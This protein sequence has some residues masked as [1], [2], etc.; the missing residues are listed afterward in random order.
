MIWIFVFVYV[1]MFV[2]MIQLLMAYQ[3]RAYN[4]RM[5]QEP[6]RRRIRL[7]KE[8]M[9]ETIDKLHDAVS[10]RLDELVEEVSGYKLQTKVLR[11]LLDRWKEAVPEEE[12]EL[13]PEEE[14]AAS[15]EEIDE[16][17][18]LIRKAALRDMR[19]LIEEL[20]TNQKE[21]E[22]HS[23]GVDRDIELVTDTMKRMQARVR[24]PA[25]TAEKSD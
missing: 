7:H 23:E 24:R 25:Q 5:K 21:L 20:A 8:A 14:L 4:L 17:Q 18:E 16:E 6:I 15:E 1:C 11:G 13:T 22:A 9:V 3:K 2:V 10:G 12:K 19:A